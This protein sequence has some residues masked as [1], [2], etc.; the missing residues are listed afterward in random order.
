[1]LFE[2]IH[3][4]VWAF[5]GRSGGTLTRLTESRVQAFVRARDR[6]RVVFI[7]KVAFIVNV[8]LIASNVARGSKCVISTSCKG[9]D[10]RLSEDF[11]FGECSIEELSGASVN[12]CCYSCAANSNGRDID[13]Q[14]AHL[15]YLESEHLKI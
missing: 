13:R 8:H 7:A 12:D 11:N 4:R 2:V 10:P 3:R 15:S 5:I 1:L 9:G 6:S 14:V